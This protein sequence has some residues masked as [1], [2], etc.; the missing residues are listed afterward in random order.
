MQFEEL[1]FVCQEAAIDIVDREGVARPTVVLP[2]SE[3]TRLLALPQF[4]EDDEAR[5]ELLANLAADEIVEGQVPCWGFVAEAELDDGGDVVVVVYGARKHAPHLT[6]A[7]KL[8]DGTLDEFLPAEELAAE[9]M[10]YLHP[11]QHAVDQLPAVE[12]PPDGLSGV[13]G[14]PEDPLA[15]GLPMFGGG[16]D[17]S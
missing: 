15:G 3:K 10:P 9:A 8:G 13:R 11:L 12:T 17:G 7:V 14:T 2:G 5:H 1:R 16:S 4:P 6:A